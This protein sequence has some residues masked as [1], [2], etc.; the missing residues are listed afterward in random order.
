MQ[1]AG[2]VDDDQ[3]TQAADASS[4][5]ASFSSVVAALHGGD[6]VVH[7]LARRV[8][9][10]LAHLSNTTNSSAVAE[11]TGAVWVEAG[12]GDAAAAAMLDSIVALESVQVSPMLRATSNLFVAEVGERV[13]TATRLDYVV[14]AINVGLMSMLYLFVFRIAVGALLHEAKRT[15][16]FLRLLPGSVI[17]N[18][19]V[20]RKL[21]PSDTHAAPP[22][23]GR[24][25][26]GAA[27]PT[28]RSA[29]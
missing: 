5:A 29:M 16:E 12:S 23:R 20:L 21:F 15:Q 2:L 4:S 13:S 14:T 7:L 27:T 3:S 18:S 24:G 22:P 26:A 25:L 28:R 17:N 6:A 10:L 9:S 1:A 8:R 19:P 11:P